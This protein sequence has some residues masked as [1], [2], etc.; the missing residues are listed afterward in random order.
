MQFYVTTVVQSVDRTDGKP[1]KMPQVTRVIIGCEEPA[2][3]LFTEMCARM[4]GRGVVSFRVAQDA[5]ERSQ[6]E[7]DR[8]EA[9][10]NMVF[11]DRGSFH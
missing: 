4:T 10:L 9:L 5:P 1:G 8:A 6:D 2:R 3:K 11:A 7:K